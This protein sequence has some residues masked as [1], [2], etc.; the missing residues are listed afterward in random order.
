MNRWL[1][2]L[3][4]LCA[5]GFAG[6]PAGSVEITDESGTT[7]RLQQPARRIVS[8]APH[9]TESLFAIGAGSRVI[10]TVSYSDYPEAAKAIPIVG[11]YDRINAER[12]VAMEP[13]LVI[14]W[15]EGNSPAAIQNLRNLGIRVFVTN[16]KVLEDI[17]DSLRDF[18]RLT[19]MQDN[20][21]PVAGK[22]R[23]QVRSLEK[24]Y[25]GKQKISVFYQVWDEPLLTL[26]DNNLIAD[27]IRLC[28]GT[29]VFGAAIQPHPVV[30][31]ESVLN[32]DPQ[33]IFASGM[34]EERPDWLDEW[35][36]WP[37]RAARNRHLYFIPPSLLQRH[38]TRVIVGAR[39]MC[40]FI[41]RART[42]EPDDTG[43]EKTGAT[44]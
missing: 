26:N 42:G 28:G 40:E 32:A 18:S 35:A 21:F 37:V 14:A 4:V 6:Q 36:G 31:V 43:D 24:Q 8:L 33:V 25:A 3:L 9:I 10:G 34:G 11:S 12:V 41:D 5:P 19:G 20:G 30:N 22:F 16:P 7:L 1:F 44:S 15:L 2:L 17:P 29:N 39:K 27:V 38:S 13:D 23:R